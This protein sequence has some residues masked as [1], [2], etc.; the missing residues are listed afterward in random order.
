MTWSRYIIAGML[1]LVGCGENDG[2]RHRET[3]V[4]YDTTDLGDLVFN[5]QKTTIENKPITLTQ[6]QADIYRLKK[7]AEGIE[8]ERRKTAMLEEQR[9]ESEL[10]K[11]LEPGDRVRLK[12]SPSQHVWR[13]SLHRRRK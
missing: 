12:F 3:Q 1:L 13:D 11:K 5:L 4:I 2:R 8:V 10:W 7:W 9:R 6:E